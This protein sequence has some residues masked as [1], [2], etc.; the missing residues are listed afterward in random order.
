MRSA[1]FPPTLHVCYRKGGLG[2][3]N[4]AAISC[5][6]MLKR[7]LTRER[8]MR[9]RGINE[10]LIVRHQQRRVWFLTSYFVSVACGVSVLFLSQYARL[11]SVLPLPPANCSFFSHVGRTQRVMWWCWD[12]W[13][14]PDGSANSAHITGSAPGGPTA[15][16]FPFQPVGDC[17][18]NLECSIPSLCSTQ[19]W[20]LL[21]GGTTFFGTFT[22]LLRSLYSLA[23]CFARPSKAS[24]NYSHAHTHTR[25]H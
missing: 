22:S 17:G 1:N 12:E 14:L 18:S 6:C 19:R 21:V 20:G 11:S 23:W 4:G 13:S 2:I 7:A 16:P 25:A 24:H 9:M 3:G 8:S 15:A 10:S 5:P